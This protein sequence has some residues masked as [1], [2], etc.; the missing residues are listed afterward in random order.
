MY[1]YDD[2]TVF[3]RILAQSRVMISGRHIRYTQTHTHTR[4]DRTNVKVL[5]VYYIHKLLAMLYLQLNWVKT[6]LLKVHTDLDS[7]VKAKRLENVW[8]IRA[9]SIL[10][11]IDHIQLR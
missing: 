9:Q 2:V 4:T 8:Q 7:L 5:I 3:S 1:T 11:E 6:I 10:Q